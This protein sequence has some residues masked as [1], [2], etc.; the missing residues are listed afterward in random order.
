MALCC[1]VFHSKR[2]YSFH[3]VQFSNIRFSSRFRIFFPVNTVFCASFAHTWP[4][5]VLKGNILSFLDLYVTPGNCYLSNNCFV[6]VLFRPTMLVTR[7]LACSLSGSAK[8]L[9][10]KEEVGLGGMFF[11]DRL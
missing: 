4:K 2:K 9:P 3:G 11:H 7:L 1:V 8:L 5:T 10:N 6:F